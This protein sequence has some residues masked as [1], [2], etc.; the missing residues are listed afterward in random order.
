MGQ[1]TIS[2]GGNA[3]TLSQTGGEGF[4]LVSAANTGIVVHT[5]SG[6]GTMTTTTRS[7]DGSSSASTSG[8]A[9]ATGGAGLA[10]PRRGAGFR[11]AVLIL[12]GMMGLMGL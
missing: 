10:A 9:I 8:V 5:E 1:T 6:S 2:A 4:L 11:L 3:P 7:G 12:G